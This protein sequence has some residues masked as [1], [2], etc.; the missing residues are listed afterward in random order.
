MSINTRRL[1]LS[2]VDSNIK[3][4]ND[5]H[6]NFDLTRA[7]IACRNDQMI[8]LSLVRA[9]LPATTCLGTYQETRTDGAVTSEGPRFN[10]L[11][12]VFDLLGPVGTA[13]PHVIT[14][15]PRVPIFGTTSPWTLQTTINDIIGLINSTLEGQYIRIAQDEASLGI[16]RL[17][18][19]APATGI[20]FRVA[21]TS[22]EILRALG[23][24]T[25]AN[26]TITPTSNSPF[27]FDLSQL[28]PV[29]RVKTN[30]NFNSESSDATGDSNILD[31]LPTNTTQGNQY[32]QTLTIADASGTINI[33]NKSMML[34]ENAYMSKQIIPT[35]TINNLEIELV[36]QDNKL[37]SVGQQPFSIVIQV[38]ILDT[39]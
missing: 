10:N 8:A 2:S 27:N 32:Y 7:S 12:L 6:V 28:L 9:E 18:A 36:S 35:K 19:V 15:N 20:T 16:F 33:K 1:Y 17:Q 14:F 30:F 26:T 25:D 13:G 23:L 22:P 11:I 3:F 29:V 24:Y 34:H 38:D 5:G 39:I 37:I 31:S 21:Q 4:V